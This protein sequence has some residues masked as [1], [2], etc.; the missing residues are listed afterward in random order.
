ME[1][2][3]NLLVVFLIFYIFYRGIRSIFSGIKQS[4][5]NSIITMKGS[6]DH[7]QCDSISNSHGE[8]ESDSAV[9]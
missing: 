7:A 3:L 2:I 9:D 8:N 1:T 5:T 4:I 6:A